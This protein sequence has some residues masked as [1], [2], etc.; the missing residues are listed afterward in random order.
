MENVKVI[1]IGLGQ[2]VSNWGTYEGKP[3]LFIEPVPV[4]GKVGQQGPELP[5]HEL[6]PNSTI[7]RFHS[8]KGANVIMEDILS[9][10]NCEGK[11]DMNRNPPKSV[12]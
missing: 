3:A 4:A 8:A 10:I 6:T 9:A 1:E 5:K 7:I 2:V 12:K 11:L